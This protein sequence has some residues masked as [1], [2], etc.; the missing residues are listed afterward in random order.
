VPV[1]AMI[2]GYN[3]P[4]DDGEKVL[5]P[6][7]QFGRP[8]ADLVGPMPYAVRQTLLDEPNARNGLHRY[9]RSAFAG[10]LSD[11]FIDVAVEAASRFTSPLSA[12]V[13]FYMHGA[14]TRVPAAIPPSQRVARSGIS[15]FSASGTTR[16]DQIAMSAGSGRRGT[17]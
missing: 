6:A 13:F 16:P 2:L 1:V 12:M 4:L 7:R 11:Q 14:A 8:L 17:R 10:Q 15:T 5:A 3:G 9:W